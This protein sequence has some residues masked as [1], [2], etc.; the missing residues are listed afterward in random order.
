MSREM[1]NWSYLYERPVQHNK[2]INA[3]IETRKITIRHI[4]DVC[5]SRRTPDAINNIVIQLRLTML[6]WVAA[7]I[8]A[9]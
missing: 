2:Y 9:L 6:S 3:L 1:Q 5:F 4:K 7:L 8:A